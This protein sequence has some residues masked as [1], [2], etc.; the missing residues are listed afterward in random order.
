M[1]RDAHEQGQREKWENP[2]H[3][4]SIGPSNVDLQLSLRGNTVNKECAVGNVDIE[5]LYYR[6]QR[7]KIDRMPI[8][9]IE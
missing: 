8:G 7:V 6:P 4:T 2:S 9:G 3:E 1:P 5:V